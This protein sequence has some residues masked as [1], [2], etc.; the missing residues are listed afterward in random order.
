M[1]TVRFEFKI[2]SKT[3]SMLDSEKERIELAQII[4]G[5]LRDA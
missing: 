2:D 4:D 3:L 1:E 5:V